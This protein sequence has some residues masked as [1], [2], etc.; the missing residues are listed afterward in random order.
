M[1]PEGS[2]LGR[3]N[4]CIPHPDPGGVACDLSP[5]TINYVVS[6]LQT[7]ILT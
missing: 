6:G 7:R 3:K 1:T 5:Q 2:N 4:E